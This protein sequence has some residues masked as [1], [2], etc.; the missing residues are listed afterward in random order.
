[1]NSTTIKLLLFTMFL[2]FKITAFASEIHVKSAIGTYIG[3]E[4]MS[5][6]EIK[7]ESLN[8]AKLKALET[9]GVKENIQAYSQYLKSESNNNYAEL[10]S[11]DVISQMQ[12]A[13][14]NVTINNIKIEITKDQ[15]IKV[16]TDIS[17]TVLVYDKKPD[18]S[19]KSKVSGIESFYKSGKALSFNIEASKD[20]YIRAFVISNNED[21]AFMVFPNE[22]EKNFMLEKN[23]LYSFPTKSSGIEIVLETKNE[24]ENYNLIIVSLKKDIPFVS[25][26]SFKNIA[27]YIA[28]IP[29]DE[30]CIFTKGFVVSGK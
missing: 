27:D 22:Y 29:L 13:V 6:K 17:C 11:S 7:K 26:V 9:A 23:K 24:S 15:L 2:F 4:D 28:E 12:G 14:K 8:N 16:I 10:F 3:N 25:K 30:K 20:A 19:F 18:L 21:E 1:M 5:L